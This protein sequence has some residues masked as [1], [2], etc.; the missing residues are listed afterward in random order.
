[1]YDNSSAWS[2]S[3]NTR[4]SPL[5]IYCFHSSGGEVTYLDKGSVVE[6]A[7]LL[8]GW[9]HP[10]SWPGTMLTWVRLSQEF[11]PTNRLQVVSLVTITSRPRYLS[12]LP[13]R[14]LEVLGQEKM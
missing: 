14:P 9:S 7:C 11:S 3:E 2:S 10:A 1:M 4:G 6:G 8:A 12:S 5:P 13:K